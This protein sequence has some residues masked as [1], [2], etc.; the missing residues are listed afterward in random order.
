MKQQIVHIHGGSAFD[1]H[2]Q[3]LHTL[4]NF[5]EFSPEKKEE[6]KK[7]KNRYEEFLGEEKYQ[8]LRPSFPC[9]DN[10]KYNEW[11]IY[12]EKVIPFLDENVIFV[13]HSL[14][15]IFITK[16]LSE[17]ILPKKIA[18]LHLV[19]PVYDHT[20]EIEQ[21]GDFWL[22][23]G[24]ENSIAKNSIKEIFIYHSTDD[25]ICP[26]T[27]SEKYHEKLPNSKLQIF[28]DRFHFIGEDFPE[29]FENIRN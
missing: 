19:S 25:T 26:I 9:S 13:G 2:K 5:I 28:A 14:G 24:W 22:V 1:S 4:K 20:S 15:G 3:Y 6:R 16:Y 27:E 21:L 8:I 23:D 17:N 11:K 18:Q 29:L 7:W 10:A 12:F